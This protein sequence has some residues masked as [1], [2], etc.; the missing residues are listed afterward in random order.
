M[1]IYHLEAKMVSRGAG[2][3]AVAAS[4]Y[5][6]CS[7]MLNEYDGVQHDYT[8]KQGLVW[9]AVFLPDMAPVEWQ[10]REKLWNAVE[11]TE[12]T[13][14]SRLARE[15]V[16]A[17]P[18]ELSRQQQI[19]LLQKFV[20]E[21]FV[22]EGMCA[23]VA[24]HDTD[25]HNPHAHILLTVR[26]LT[27]TGAWQYKTEKEY[28]CVKGGEERGFT[29]AEFKSAQA[30]G[31]E[32]QYQYKVDKKKV[33]MAP[34]QAEKCGYERVSKY[35]KSTKY[36]RQ[37]PI[38]ARWN[39][40]EH[41]LVWREAWATAANRCLEL[42]GHA[43]RIDHRSHA[44]RGLE[45]RPTV[46][47]GVAVQALERRGIL[48]DRCELNRQIKA[49]NALLRELK[50]ELKK[51]SDLVVHTVSAVAE[52][53]EK[54]RGRVLIFCYQLSHIRAGRE[55]YQD[56]LHV[57]RPQMARYNGLVRQIKDKSRERKALL[58]EKKALPARKIFKH[59]ELAA[60][61]A[62]LTED[63]EE[64]RSEKALLL[65]QFEYAEDAGAETFRKDIAALESNLQKLDEQE[66]KYSAAL[67]AALHEYAEVKSQAAGLDPVEL[68]EARQAIR[69]GQEAAANEKLEQVF[70]S[71]YSLLRWMDAKQA[72]IRLTNDSLEEY[73]ARQQ[74]KQK[75][76]SISQPVR[77][78]NHEQER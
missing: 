5:L 39:S 46:H 67:D 54:L 4:A 30:E 7:R 15:F 61:I 74:A 34:S 51:L 14:D 58:A 20:R 10:D 66:Q 12:K 18:I 50:A 11:E 59:K 28:L 71:K 6:S 52:R 70:G 78:R 24:V 29:A 64:L 47:E 55:R 41:L 40:E 23:D 1:A 73:A 60:R 33:Y 32:K 56:A 26:P 22:A 35:P 62:E 27:E 48:S 76:K 43:E 53:L 65:Q 38:S 63:L 31:W 17:L 75:Y 3:S 69:L 2:R 45:E 19:A 16:A 36:G 77:K 21:Q 9:Q 49:D 72:Q 8:R 42:A 37:N 13:K 44:A 25:G 68:Y 57:Y